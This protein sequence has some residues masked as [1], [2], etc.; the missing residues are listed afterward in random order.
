MDIS[1][2]D[3]GIIFPKLLFHQRIEGSR[4]NDLLT[5]DTF[6][7]MPPYGYQ[8]GKMGYLNTNHLLIVRWLKVIK[9]LFDHLLF[10]HG[11]LHLSGLLLSTFG[12]THGKMTHSS[13]LSFK[14]QYDRE[15]S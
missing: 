2:F 6:V 7:H 9:E 15:L 11:G 13:F 1:F 8:I 5:Y 3:L 12:H 10:S 14:D 4:V